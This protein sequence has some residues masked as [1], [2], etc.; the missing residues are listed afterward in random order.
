M[1]APRTMRSFDW[2][3]AGRDFGESLSGYSALVVIGIDPVATGRV[4]IGL[5]RAQAAHRRV[6]VGDLFAES[7]PIQELVSTDDPH[8]L[9][10]SFL[11]GVSLSRIAYPVPDAGQ[12]FV[13]PSGTEPP[14]YEEILPNPRWQRLAAGFREVGALLVLAVPASAPHIEDLVA[15]ADGAVVVGDAAPRQLPLAA[16]IGSVREP[17]TTA[18]EPPPS[19]ASAAETPWFK[20]RLALIPG[21]A[22][23]LLLVAIGLWL[24]YRPLDRSGKSSA[25]R[26]PDTTKGLAN[27]PPVL[28]DSIARNLAADSAASDRMSAAIPRVINPEDSVAAAVFAVE[29]LA[30]NTQAGAILKLQ[31]DGKNLPAATFA[32]VLIQNA[33]W[34]KVIAGAYTRRGEADSLLVALRRRR[35]L[36]AASGAVVRVPFAFL[37]DSGVPQ[38]AVTGMVATYADR[39]QPVYALRQ[40][41]GSAWLLAGAFESFAQSSLYAESLRA[42]GITPVLVYRKGRTF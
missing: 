2:E 37:I 15:A 27:V 5:G 6:A 4:A 25:G 38:G 36:D 10:D 20:R 23:T 30:A 9:V 41:N 12:L 24:A 34:F 21:A 1:T 35:V 16:I 42:S 29:L 31:Q 22:L 17:K 40:P 13:M 28:A 18:V 8:G 33:R 14:T 7:P 19:A 32:P 11:Y 26:N 3:A 39:G